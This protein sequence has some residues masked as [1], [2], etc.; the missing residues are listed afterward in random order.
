MTSKIFSFTVLVLATP[1]LIGSAFAMFHN[2]AHIFTTA[3]MALLVGAALFEPDN[4][5]ENLYTALKRV[6]RGQ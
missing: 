5:G 6:F 4:Y 3:V 1:L 2:P